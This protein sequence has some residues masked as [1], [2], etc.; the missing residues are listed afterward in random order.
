MA[1]HHKDEEEAVEKRNDWIV[2]TFE[3]DLISPEGF[4]SKFSEDV[5]ER[6]VD[7]R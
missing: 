7:S 4:R 3:M 6:L 5:Y 2:R 1:F